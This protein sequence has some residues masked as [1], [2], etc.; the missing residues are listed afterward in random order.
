MYVIFFRSKFTTS[1]KIHQYPDRDYNSYKRDNYSLIFS[2]FF[3]DSKAFDK[4]ATFSSVRSSK[5]IFRL[6]LVMN[7]ESRP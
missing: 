1:T 5:V 6:N 7:L 3:I 2:E 4:T